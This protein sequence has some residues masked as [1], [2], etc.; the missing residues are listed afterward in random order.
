MSNFY[1]Y[2]IIIAGLIA[3]SIPVIII[4]RRK[5]EKQI[6]DVFGG[7]QE[8]TDRDFYERYFEAKGVPFYVVK[9]IREILE[10][11][12][13][14]D[15]SRLSAE[16]DFSKNL[17]FFWHED[18]LADVEIFEKIEEEFD[19][20]FQ[21]ADFENL[22]TTSVNDIVEIVWRKVKEKNEFGN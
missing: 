18:S 13:D 2:L 8:L 19:I 9:K 11:V 6:E 20:K 7:R 16:D 5:Q 17:N 10:D 14:A 21:P 4:G 3:A 1:I 22:Q 15:L 12:L